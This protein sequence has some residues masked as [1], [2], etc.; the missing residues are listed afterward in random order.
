VHRLLALGDSYTCG[1]GVTESERWPDQLVE[2]LRRQQIPLA[3]PEIVA[4]TAWTTDELSEAI[5]AVAPKGP[6]DLVT[7]LIGVNDQYRARP[8]VGFATEFALLL[9]R[10]RD[11]AGRRPSRVVAISIPDWG[12]TPFAEGRDRALI[13]REVD[14]YNDRARELVMATGARWVDITT[15]SRAMQTDGSLVARDG[16]HPSAALY[17][18][19]AE[20]MLPIA[21]VALKTP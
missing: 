18:K 3:E 13:G 9:R 15:I 6:Y 5:D 14:A 20:A 8:V 2:M 21:S 19:W 11:F 17:R 12:A 7:L 4:R 10:A 1:E 16:L